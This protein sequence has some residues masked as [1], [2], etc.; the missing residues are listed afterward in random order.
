MKHLPWL[1][2]ITEAG[3][4][5][6]LGEAHCVVWRGAWLG[7]GAGIFYS[8]CLG[9]RANNRRVSYRGKTVLAVV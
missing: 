1:S 4:N 6:F 9:V 3:W 8:D 7:Y 5:M 2:R